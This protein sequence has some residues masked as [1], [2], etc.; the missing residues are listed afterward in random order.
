MVLDKVVNFNDFSRPNKE[1]KYFSK[2]STEFEDFSRQLLNFNTFSRL[3]EPCA[4]KE[5]H[6][7]S[8]LKIY[9]EWQKLFFSLVKEGFFIVE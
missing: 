3:Y 5:L 9:I 1:I 6:I 8:F 2:T 4:A 7:S